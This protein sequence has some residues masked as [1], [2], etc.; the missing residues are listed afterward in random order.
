MTLKLAKQYLNLTIKTLI[1]VL[2]SNSVLWVSV[3]Q[4]LTLTP[5]FW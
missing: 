1:S 4:M 3:G 5:V 2:I